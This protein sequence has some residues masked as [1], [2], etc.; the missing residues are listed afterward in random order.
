MTMRERIAKRVF[1]E[2]YPGA[3]W[4]SAVVINGHEDF[5]SIADAVLSELE[6]PTEGMLSEARA[7]WPGAAAAPFETCIEVSFIASIRAAKDGK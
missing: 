5:Y 2:C 3:G 1:E 7:A 4:G 6:T